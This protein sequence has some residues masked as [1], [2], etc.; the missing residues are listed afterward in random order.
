MFIVAVTE[1]HSWRN[2]CP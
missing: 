2:W 1:T